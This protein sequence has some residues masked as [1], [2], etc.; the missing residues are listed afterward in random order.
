LAAVKKQNHHSVILD[1]STLK[2]VPAKTM[3]FTVV[4]FGSGEQN[5]KVLP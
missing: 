1:L 5:E 3:V 2:F 4:Y